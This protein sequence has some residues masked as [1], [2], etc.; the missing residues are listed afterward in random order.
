MSESDAGS[1][2]SKGI[3]GPTFKASTIVGNGQSAQNCGGCGSDSVNANS[4]PHGDKVLIQG[5]SATSS[6]SGPSTAV[7]NSGSGSSEQGYYATLPNGQDHKIS[8]D[9][10]HTHS[11]EGSNL[12]N[13]YLPPVDNSKQGLNQHYRN[14]GAYN[15]HL[16]GVSVDIQGPSVHS[17]IA[18]PSNYDSGKYSNIPKPSSSDTFSFT[19]PSHTLSIQSGPSFPANHFDNG[20]NAAENQ[21]HSGAVEGSSSPLFTNDDGSIG[22]GNLH[23]IITTQTGEHSYAP[24]LGVDHDSGVQS[25]NT[26]SDTNSEDYPEF[27]SIKAT[28]IEPNQPSISPDYSHTALFPIPEKSSH[29]SGIAVPNGSNQNSNGLGVAIQGPSAYSTITVPQNSVESTKLSTDQG[30]SSSSLSSFSSDTSNNNGDGETSSHP[31][32]VIVQDLGNSGDNKPHSPFGSH[33]EHNYYDSSSFAPPTYMRPGYADDNSAGNLQFDSQETGLSSF[34]SGASG[35]DYD[36]YILKLPLNTY[37]Y[38][39]PTDD[40]VFLKKLVQSAAEKPQI[41]YVHKSHHHHHQKH[42]Y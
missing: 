3:I 5:P 16:R 24:I 42:S 21:D 8:A 27:S 6:I 41:F 37:A 9:C 14:D 22:S 1:I 12:K 29:K 2:S 11:N 25:T 23:T 34:D 36:C 33:Q 30:F 26:D 40:S 15:E 20:A 32:N 28:Y 39:V 4:A 35:S 7:D 10:D 18:G 17:T 19:S 13:G 38:I 31:K